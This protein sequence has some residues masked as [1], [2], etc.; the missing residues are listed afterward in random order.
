MGVFIDINL[1]TWRELGWMGGF[2]NVGK[3]E[4]EGTKEV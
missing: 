2:F 3:S 1:A 4:V